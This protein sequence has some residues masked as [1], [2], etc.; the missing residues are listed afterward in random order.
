MPPSLL[1]IQIN[2]SV[3]KSKQKRKTLIR[4]TAVNEWLH[5]I[6][7]VKTIDVSSMSKQVLERL[8]IWLA[9]F[10]PNSCHR[11]LNDIKS[12][13]MTWFDFYFALLNDYNINQLIDL[14]DITTLDSET[15]LLDPQTI[16]QSKFYILYLGVYYL[17]LRYM[18][19]FKY[20]RTNN[21][22]KRLSTHFTNKQ[23]PQ[24][25]VLRIFNTVNDIT[26]ENK[27]KEIFTPY[28]LQPSQWYNRE[29]IFAIDD[30]DI[31]TNCV[32]NINSEIDNEITVEELENTKKDLSDQKEINDALKELCAEQDRK[33]TVLELESKQK[34]EIINTLRKE[35]VALRK[36]FAKLTTT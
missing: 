18:H 19:V 17:N 29:E 2:V 28:I 14:F 3:Y 33:I 6:C 11:M 31:I 23:F 22:K 16:S 26:L 30:H 35:F 7:R 10:N 4:Y 24:V 13:D 20:G 25:C 1:C 21:I 36:T 34:D 32:I 9:K 27:M 8:I 12:S 15:D 5:Y